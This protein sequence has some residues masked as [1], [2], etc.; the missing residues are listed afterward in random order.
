[1]NA[2]AATLEDLLA[3]P[4][5]YVIPIFQRY[6]S[7]K[8][9]DWETLWDDIENLWS[10][11]Q[12]QVADP[13]FIGSIVLDS[14][15]QKSLRRPKF[16]VIDG[17]QRLVTLS[18]LMCALRN[19][20]SNRGFEELCST[21]EEIVLYI[22]RAKGEDR[23]RVYP[24]QQDR[25]HYLAAVQG[26]S[27]A[28]GTI[29][30]ALRFFSDRIE[31]LEEADTEDQLEEFLYLLLRRL[32]FV[33]IIL[34]GENAYQ[35][36]SSL[37]STGQAL[38]EADLVRN[39]VFMQ[40]PIDEQDQFDR[41]L[42]E[43]IERRFKNEDGRVNGGALSSFLRDF[44]MRTGRY[45]KPDATFQ[46]FD[47]RYSGVGF[48]P[49]DLAIELGWHAD[50]YDILKGTK[51]H[52][53]E[54]VE[55]ALNKLRGL[56]VSTTF[57]LLLNLLHRIEEGSID[58]DGFVKCV[59]MLSGFVLRRYVCGES[60]RTYYRW[61]VSACRELGDHPV[62]NLEAFLRDKG[63]PDD[64]RFKSS[65]VRFN[66][67]QSDYCSYTLARLEL[68]NNHREAPD[69]SKTQIEHILPQSLT[70]EWR[71]E[72]GPENERIHW[73]RLHTPGNLTLTA[74]NQELSNHSFGIKRQEYEK[75]NIYITRQLAKSSSWGEE[76]IRNRGV[77]LAETAAG[78][79]TA[80]NP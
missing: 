36:F 35:I 78:I 55:T 23:L 37:N 5:Q 21:V 46:E 70:D 80:H 27:E 44:L 73:E 56:N 4:N 65:F 45:V 12:G 79:W 33:H 76:E 31:K 41:D 20:A 7:W 74:Y 15:R 39:F 19:I 3:V 28:G 25:H 38:S 24:R 66:L 68:S 26:E 63:Y 47:K 8:R 32:E 58:E 13:H 18:L 61:F 40:V 51:K 29:G 54:L 75:S 16:Q 14:Q 60:S 17:Q 11:E 2:D 30:E 72:L 9:E 22:P 48:Q 42:W 77:R 6:Y 71:S 59:D 10:P 67:Y 53:S 62:E 43:P 1:M 64:E 52:D 57:P 50:Y 69:L 34:E 49:A